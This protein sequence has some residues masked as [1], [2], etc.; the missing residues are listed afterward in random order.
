MIGE[1]GLWWFSGGDGCCFLMRY[2]QTS[3]RRR[4]RAIR[5]TG[6][7]CR[8]M[9]FLEIHFSSKLRTDICLATTPRA[10]DGKLGA[11]CRWELACLLSCS[12][13]QGPKVL[14]NAA[15]SFTAFCCEVLCS[16]QMSDLALPAECF[17]GDS[18]AGNTQPVCELL[19]L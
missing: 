16:W 3:S 17:A 1:Q 6:T 14:P 8:S 11:C 18:Q 2:R 15:G 9:A 5:S 10:L 7:S 4:K 12:P 19:S 13:R